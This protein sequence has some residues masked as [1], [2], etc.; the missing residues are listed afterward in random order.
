MIMSNLAVTLTVEQ[1]KEIVQ[2]AVRT[3]VAKAVVKAPPDVLN[4]GQAAEFLDRHPHM[5]MRYVRAKRL[6]AHFISPREPRF[7]R[8]DLLAFLDAL[9]TQPGAHQKEDE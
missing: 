8:R 7:Y 5:V 3:E 9:P 2:T 4:L 1:L 6:V